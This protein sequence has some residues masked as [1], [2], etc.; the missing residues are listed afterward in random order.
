MR[1]IL[2]TTMAFLLDFDVQGKR[3]QPPIRDDDYQVIRPT[4]PVGPPTPKQI[5]DNAFTEVA[6]EVEVPVALLRAICWAESAHDPLAY[7]HGDGRGTNHAFGICQVLH[8]T[9]RSLGLDDPGCYRDFSDRRRRTREGC[10]LFDLRTGILYGARYLKYHL[11]TQGGN[12][13]RAIAAYN[14]GSVR[15][16]TSGVVR[17]ASDGEVLWTCAVGDILNRAY[18]NKVQ[19]ALKE[20]R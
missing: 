17:R 11:E 12:Q 3:V 18:I 6:N 16:C 20:G 14:A 9:A 5:L 8:S 4:D 19:T 13:E 2:L 7:A 15:I 10:Q 1:T